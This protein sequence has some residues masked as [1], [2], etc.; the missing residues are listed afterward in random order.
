MSWTLSAFADEAAASCEAQIIA[1]QRAGLSRLDLRSI[2][3]HNVSALPLDVAREVRDRLDETGISVQMLGSPLGKID[4]A[5]DFEAELQKLRHLGALAPI[6]GCGAIRIFSYFNARGALHSQWM[7][8]SL[9]RLE[10][11]RAEAKNLGLVLYHE[12]ER[13]IFGE[14][15]ENVSHVAALRDA[16][17]QLIFDFDNYN[18]A[19]ED[20]WQAWQKLASVTDAFHLKDSTRATQNAPAQHVPAGQG[21]GQI[22][23]I[24]GDALAHTWS[25]PVSVEPHL[26]HSGAVA[27]TGPCGAQNSVFSAMAPAESFHLALE[28]AKTVLAG[29][30]ANWN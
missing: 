18:Q 2:E 17:F 15:T 19:G 7:E 21:N 12:N 11:L 22:A 13:H 20:V 29:V 1:L 14:M 24:L 26:T 28:A 8:T 23:A 25:G 27:A 6:L 5:D 9:S 10:R 30:G 4:I 3:G 16:N